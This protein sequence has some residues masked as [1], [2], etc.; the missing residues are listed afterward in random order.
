[1]EM[2]RTVPRLEQPSV[3]EFH[4]KFLSRG[5]PVVISG[6]MAKWRALDL[7]SPDY[8]AKT[9]G[10][11]TLN[12]MAVPNGARGG[13]F[14]PDATNGFQGTQIELR[15]YVQEICST[16]SPKFYV[17]YLKLQQWLPDLG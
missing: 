2:K 11:T 15:D 4:Q 12:V 5:Q 3:E 16:S 13:Y 9:H 10:T 7:W 14:H 6:A 8:F 17:V 1:M